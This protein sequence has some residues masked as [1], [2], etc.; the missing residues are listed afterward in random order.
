MGLPFGGVFGAAPRRSFF[1]DR[2][3]GTWYNRV[4]ES[5]RAPVS[6]GGQKGQA[7]M[8]G[9]GKRGSGSRALKTVV[10]LAGVA[11]IVCLRAFWVLPAYVSTRSM[12]PTLRPGD[13]FLVNRLAYRSHR[14]AAGDVVAVYALDRED[15]WVK[16]V[17]AGPGDV[18]ALRAGTLYRN[19]RPVREPYARKSRQAMLRVKVPAGRFFVLGDNRDNSEDSR[20]WGTLKRDLII[21]KVALIYW[22]S[23]RTGRVR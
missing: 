18:V 12:E 19:G 5:V 22:P 17:V 9:S 14:P 21:G 8:S 11:G 6:V 15:V 1:V 4:R 13:F 3:A 23:G 7:A 2:R 10:L 16:R 20:T